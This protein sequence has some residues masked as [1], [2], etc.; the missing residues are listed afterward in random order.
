MTIATA[1]PPHTVLMVHVGRRLLGFTTG[2]NGKQ[3]LTA[4]TGVK[5]SDSIGSPR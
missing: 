4:A 5:Q 2:P 3:F 1:V